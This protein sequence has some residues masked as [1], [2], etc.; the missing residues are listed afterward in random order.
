M[1]RVMPKAVTRATLPLLI[2]LLGFAV[3]ALMAVVQQGAAER[4]QQL[5]FEQATE[6]Q[7]QILDDAVVD[8]LN[9][10]NGVVD[11]VSAV[12]PSDVAEFRRFFT[13]SELVGELSNL[14][15]GVMVMELVASDEVSDLEARERALGNEDF[16]VQFLTPPASDSH[17]VITRTAR[18]VSF[19]LISVDGLEV[20]GLVSELLDGTTPPDGQ[21]IQ[22]LNSN[23]ILNQ[24]LTGS[25]V[26]E[27]AK[28]PVVVAVTSSIIDPDTGLTTAW[29]V[30]LFD[31]TTLVT[32]ADT[33]IDRRLNVVVSMSVLGEPV[34]LGET[35]EPIPFDDAPLSKRVSSVNSGLEWTTSMWASADFGVSTGLFDQGATWTFGLLVTAAVVLGAVWRAVQEFQLTRA[36]FE[37]EHARTLASTDSLTGLLNRQGFL[38][39]VRSLEP[40][41]S[42]TIFFIDLDGFK[43]VNDTRGHEGGDSVL[44]E[45]ATLISSQFRAHDLVGRF[46]G[47]EFAV[48]TPDL[49]GDA[50]HADISQRVIDSLAILEDQVSCSVGATTKVASEHVDVLELIRRADKAMYLA[51]QRGGGRYEAT[52]V[53]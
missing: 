21:M 52:D 5:M 8:H 37:L 12:F 42:G 32:G 46:G 38:D 25:Q 39:G 35:D 7:Q 51:K 53:S 31:P 30:R 29:V 2:A 49:I 10:V 41:T 17:I 6:R 50:H 19:G 28:T 13:S 23:S 14:D 4:E 36:N 11:F 27:A 26:D 22:A 48:F 1:A 20:S 34:V 40:S 43:Q 24:F 9:D 15:P 33:T 18:D 47:D 16:N 44:R 3:T 45:A